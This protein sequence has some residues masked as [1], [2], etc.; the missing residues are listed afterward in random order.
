MTTSSL[1]VLFEDPFWIGLFEIIDQKGL[2]VCKVTFGAEPTEKEVMEFGAA[3]TRT[4]AQKRALLRLLRRLKMEHPDA[5]ILCHR[6][7]PDV[8][9]DCPCYDV[10]AELKLAGI[11]QWR[12]CRPHSRWSGDSHHQ[13]PART[14]SP[15]WTARVQGS[16]P[17]LG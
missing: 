8:H 11:I 9:K 7:L 16:Q 6:D 12:W 10:L 14:S 1:T 3:D 13:R 4:Q 17:M 5:R 2:R 15:G